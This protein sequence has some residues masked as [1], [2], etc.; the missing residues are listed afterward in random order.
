MTGALRTGAP[1][2]NM[3]GTSTATMDYCT[4]SLHLDPEKENVA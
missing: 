2:P 3:R 4:T 1:A